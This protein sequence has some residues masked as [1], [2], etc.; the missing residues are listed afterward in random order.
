MKVGEIMTRDV[1]I[2]NPGET[3]REAA[4]EMEKCDIGVLPVGEHDRLVGMI[5]DRDIAI[6][7]VAHGLGPEARVRD[8]MSAEVKYCF[9]SDEVEAL[10]YNM[11][12]QQIR[13]L[14]VL[15]EQKRLVGIVALADMATSKD[16]LAPTVALSGISQ[17]GGPHNQTVTAVLD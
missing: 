17:T 13:R 14:P 4:A 12:D 15:S 11:A 8:V 10:A 5:T 7:G 2:A 9:E 3:L 1:C 6:R 16:A